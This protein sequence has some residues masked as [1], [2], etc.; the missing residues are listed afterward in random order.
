MSPR[1]S[2]IHL[3]WAPLGLAPFK[4][5]VASYR[6][7]QAGSEHQL[8]V[9]FNGIGNRQEAEVYHR[10]LDGLAYQSVVLEE[11][12]LDIPA[13]LT[14]AQRIRSEWLCFLNSY[15]VIRSEN[16]LAKLYQHASLP[17]VGLVGATGSWESRYSSF[18]QAHRDAVRSLPPASRPLH[19]GRRGVWRMRYELQA[20]RLGM[21]FHA[22]PNAHIRSNAF[23]LARE[24]M[25]RLRVPPI[26]EKLG[27]E[28]F[29]SG[30]SSMTR[31]VVA[32]GLKALVVGSD[33]VAYS[34]D[35]WPDSATFRSG[36]QRNLLVE[37]NRTR[38]YADADH[39]MRQTLAGMA[40]G[41][42]ANA[43]RGADDSVVQA[44]G[45]TP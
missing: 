34:E 39:T 40:W 18:R 12:T 16:W 29:E 26:R 31:Q 43:D 14:A 2:V 15:S 21:A 17:G 41:A 20:A 9:V 19:H 25:L 4:E 32:R 28:R 37:D 27:A 1:I 5:F 24:S 7:H 44:E 6:E 22:F 35:H 36:D 8:V 38:Q 13:Y 30:R 33:G 42:G 3:V 45:W 11:P 23:M 10:V